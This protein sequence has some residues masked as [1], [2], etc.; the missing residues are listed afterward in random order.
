MVGDVHELKDLTE[1][2]KNI[3][4]IIVRLAGI[5]VFIMIIIGGFQ[6]LTSGGDPK[7]AQSARNTIT[8]AIAGLVAILFAWFIL[9]FLSEFTGLPQLLEFK[10]GQ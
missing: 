6:Y 8:Y 4:N 5:M 9:R 3:F 10:I 7:K 1:I 2:I